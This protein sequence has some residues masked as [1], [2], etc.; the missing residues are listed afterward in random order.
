MARLEGV[1]QG[2]PC[3]RNGDPLESAP[4]VER[5]GDSVTRAPMVRRTLLDLLPPALA[6]CTYCGK[7][8]YNSSA[9]QRANLEG[10]VSCGHPNSVE[11]V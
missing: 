3:D 6:R 7:A 8:Y 1:H 9:I 4:P 11:I 5:I 10:C 2:T